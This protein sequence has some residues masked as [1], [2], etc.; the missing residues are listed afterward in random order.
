MARVL[1]GK[2]I[3]LGVTGSIA[4]YKALDLASKLTQAGSVVDTVMSYGATQFVTPLAFRSI[5][6]RPV[7]TNT[8]DAGSDL[9]FL[10]V[11]AT[12]G[13]KISDPIAVHIPQQ[14]EVA[15]ELVVVLPLDAV[16]QRTRFRLGALLRQDSLPVRQPSAQKNDSRDPPRQDVHA[17]SIDPR[18]YLTNGKPAVDRGEEARG[19][20]HE[21]H[22][23]DHPHHRDRR[24]IERAGR[25]GRQRHRRTL[26]RHL[27]WSR[28]G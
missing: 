14:R 8:F 25:H 1:E 12:A 9:R 19:R 15:P 3:V 28:R 7:V 6:H 27:R 18:T 16:D 20:D 23:G 5:T 10:L 2:H 4:C 11:S 22:R 26:R 24:R 17:R 13:G 21:G